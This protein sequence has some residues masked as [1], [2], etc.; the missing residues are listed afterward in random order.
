MGGRAKL[1]SHFYEASPKSNKYNRLR[2]IVMITEPLHVI[3]R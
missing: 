1:Y 2:L 3:V